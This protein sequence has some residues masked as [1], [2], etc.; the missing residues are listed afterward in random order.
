M[1]DGVT[2]VTKPWGRELIYANTERYIGKI[3]E[4]EAGSR[5]SLQ[6]HRHKDE[7]IYVLEG[8]LSLVIGESADALETHDLPA[9]SSWHV[10]PGVVH[11]FA[12]PHGVVRVLEVST[13]HPDDVVRVS[14]DYGREDAS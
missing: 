5:L 3:I 1:A 10:R 7:S 12:A 8:T 2:I 14:D 4:V 6:Y 13:P 9:G 11:R